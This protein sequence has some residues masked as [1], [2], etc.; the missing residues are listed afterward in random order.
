[1][2][3]VAVKREDWCR[4]SVSSENNS[5]SKKDVLDKRRSPFGKMR[6]RVH[7]SWFRVQ[8]YPRVRAAPLIVGESDSAGSIGSKGST[9]V[10]RRIKI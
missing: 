10:V 9:G 2:R 8:G 5:L 4:S 3:Y 7:G 6:L 1:M